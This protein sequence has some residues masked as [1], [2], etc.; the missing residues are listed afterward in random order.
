M[1]PLDGIDLIIQPHKSLVQADW[2]SVVSN[3]YTLPTTCRGAELDSTGS[4]GV[5]EIHLVGDAADKWYLMPLDVSERRG[6]IFNKIRTTNTT[7]DLAK[8]TCFPIQ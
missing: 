4:A 5:I 1:G 2:G 3:V 7:V 8:V 6:A